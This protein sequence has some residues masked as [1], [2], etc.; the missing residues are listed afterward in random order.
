MYLDLREGVWE[1]SQEVLVALN[2]RWPETHFQSRCSMYRLVP[3]T[4][5][6]DRK[7]IAE[8]TVLAMRL[9]DRETR[10]MAILAPRRRMLTTVLRLMAQRT[11]ARASSSLSAC[12]CALERAASVLSARPVDRDQTCRRDRGDELSSHGF[13]A[14]IFQNLVDFAERVLTQ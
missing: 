6:V 13:R 11:L 14:R 5:K 10:T 1:V 8:S 4:I 7:S 12:F 2:F 9:I 3:R